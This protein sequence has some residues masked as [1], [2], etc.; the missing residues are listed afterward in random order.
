MLRATPGLDRARSNHALTPV[1]ALAVEELEPALDRAAAFAR[2]HGIRLGIQVSPDHLHAELERLLDERGW[3]AQ[4]PTV[5]MA[6]APGMT[7]A[8]DGLIVE[9]HASVQWAA[10]WARCEGRPDVQAHVD[11][12]FALLRGRARFARLGDDAVAIAVPG[13]GLLGLYCIAVAPQR[14]RTGL[15]RAIVTALCA[16]DPE[17][18][19]YLQVDARN[20]GAIALY[21]QLGFEEAYRYRHRTHREP[22]G[23]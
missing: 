4:W 2:R 5:V 12:V 3:E 18:T 16:R 19:P 9:N 17:A 6:A 7:D 14:R 13:E 11:T 8:G 23:S 10:A 15:G 20:G 22:D 21:R 1:R